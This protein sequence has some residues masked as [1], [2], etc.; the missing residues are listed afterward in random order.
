MKKRG[1]KQVGNLISKK[2]RSNVGS[3]EDEEEEEEDYSSTEDTGMV[4]MQGKR[5]S[6]SIGSSSSKKIRSFLR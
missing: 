1:V 6:N 4:N 3:E 5:Q 2:K